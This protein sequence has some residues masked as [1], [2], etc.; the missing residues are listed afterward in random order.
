[1][2]ILRAM[3]DVGT[4]RNFI[5]YGES[6]GTGKTSTAQAI[7]YDLFGDRYDEAVYHFNASQ[8]A[9]VKWIREQLTRIMNYE[10]PPDIP[11]FLIIIDEADGTKKD[12]YQLVMRRF[13]EEWY[14]KARFIVC[15]NYLRK[16]IQPIQS[17]CRPL[18]F[19]PLHERDIVSRLQTIV[20]AEKID[21]ADGVIAKIA[22]I[23]EGRLRDA[24]ETL[25]M[26]RFLRRTI[27]IKDVDQSEVGLS[28]IEK[29]Y[30]CAKAGHFIKA[31]NA[32]IEAMTETGID[33]FNLVGKMMFVAMRDT[34]VKASV[35]AQI[36]SEIARTHY[37]MT[38]APSTM[39]QLQGLLNRVSIAVKGS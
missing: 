13:I 8:N 7:G 15:C 23:S 18:F 2:R 14:W 27:E 11:F 35:K 3:V 19:A 25:D 12:G 5:F 1:M 29:I 30:E 34:S 36:G 17:R 28:Y 21:V 31:R 6:P 33:T 26:L 16:I 24:I 22:D 4:M 39:I 20:D 38:T 37:E 9:S 32:A 10:L